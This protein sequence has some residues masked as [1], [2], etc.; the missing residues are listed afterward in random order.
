VNVFPVPMTTMAVNV[1]A[2]V[3]PDVH[4]EFASKISQLV[5][6]VNVVN[7]FPPL[8]HARTRAPAR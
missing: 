4:C 8:T 5:N 1:A 2:N 3:H 6:V 7:V